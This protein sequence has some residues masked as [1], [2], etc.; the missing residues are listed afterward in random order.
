MISFLKSHGVQWTA[1]QLVVGWNPIAVGCVLKANCPQFDNISVTTKLAC[2]C[3]FSVN[4]LSF[5]FAFNLLK[6]F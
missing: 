4:F 5:V 3:L 2:R 6:H 1:R